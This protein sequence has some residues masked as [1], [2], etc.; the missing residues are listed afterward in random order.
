M[1]HAR[2]LL[3]QNTYI[4]YIFDIFNTFDLL[5]L[6]GW[7]VVFSVQL[8]WWLDTLLQSY[9]SAFFYFYGSSANLHAINDFV[10]IT[11]LSQF[12]FHFNFLLFC[13]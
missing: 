6:Q 13:F 10:C 11:R 2:S 3:S 12:H 5:L 8:M 4:L 9:L 7:L 1:L